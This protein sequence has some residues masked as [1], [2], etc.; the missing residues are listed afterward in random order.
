MQRAAKEAAVRIIEVQGERAG[1]RHADADEPAAPVVAASV[2]VRRNYDA[3]RDRELVEQDLAA[4]L[5]GEVDEVV[6]RV[7]DLDER[8]A[9]QECLELAVRVLYELRVEGGVV[10]AHATGRGPPALAAVEGELLDAGA[11]DEAELR[12]V[13]RTDVRPRRVEEP[14][15]VRVAE[16]QAV[17]VVV[18]AHAGRVGVQRKAHQFD[19]VAAAHEAV[20]AQAEI[21]THGGARSGAIRVAVGRDEAERRLL[22][23]VHLRARHREILVPDVVGVLHLHVE[24]AEAEAPDAAADFRARA[25]VDDL[26]ARVDAELAREERHAVRVRD[27]E[28]VDLLAEAAEVEDARVLQEEIA[29]LREEQ[30]EAVEVHLARV[31]LGVGEVRVEGERTC[32]GRRQLVEDVEGG[33]ERREVLVVD[34]GCARHR[35]HD[36]LA[37]AEAADRAARH[38]VE[39][40]AA[41]VALDA[42]ESARLRHVGRELVLPPRSPAALLVDAPHV[43]HHVEAP[44]RRLGVE[45]ERLE[46]ER[47]LAGPALG[48]HSRFRVPDAVPLDLGRLIILDDALVARAVRVGREHVTVP[49]VMERVDRDQ[50]AVVGALAG[51]APHYLPNQ[52]LRLG[53]PGAHRDVEKLVVEQHSD[54]GRV[55]GLGAFVRAL[56]RERA[57]RGGVLPGRVFDAPVDLRRR[58]AFGKFLQRRCRRHLAIRRERVGRGRPI[59]RVRLCRK[60]HDRERSQHTH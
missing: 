24:H 48:V 29:R 13:L 60:Q 36:P 31:D 12:V 35:V 59:L 14:D 32:Y 30:R 43:A 7:V 45:R 46:R 15:V 54:V 18:A 22:A 20:R 38:D 40:E 9:D 34:I 3:R 57:E 2:H 10:E 52:L 41:D 47:E 25:D 26:A 27:F 58:D 56:L 21:A 49:L 42:R 8:R 37:V 16:A 11:V 39:S 55:G 4:R 28:E 44:G 6:E 5:R 53:I 51:V 1:L 33:I 23:Q 50:D 17:G 19:V